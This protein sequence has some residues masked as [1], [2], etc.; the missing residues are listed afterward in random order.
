V[1]NLEEIARELDDA[2]VHARPVPQRPEPLT[3]AQAYDIQ[4]ASLA[5]RYARG[6]R[7]IGM[8]MGFTSRAKMA[9][10]NLSEMIWGRITD[11]MLIEAGGSVPRSRFVHPRV[12]PEVAF[13]LKRPLAG[14]IDAMTA[15]A[16]V[17]AVA[18]ALELIDSRYVDFK[19]S[20]TDV[21]ADNS[22]SSGL[23]IGAWA[24]PKVDLSNLGIVME[25]DGIAR[26]IGSTAAILSNP[27][28]SLVAAAKLVAERGEQ[29]E[30]GH[31][32]MA[33]GATAAEALQAGNHVRLRIEKLGSVAFTLT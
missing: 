12:E 15:M 23:V 16:A 32:V 29:L 30:A 17:E 10:M 18:P 6:E 26:Q 5:R 20:L 25:I 3:V 13:L 9:Q 22:S 2:M 14:H 4:S 28:Y 19:F 21:I 7:R 11:G 33:G 1:P 8:K 24:D 27:L 31:I